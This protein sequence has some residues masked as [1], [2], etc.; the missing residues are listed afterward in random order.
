MH[1]LEP[2]LCLAIAC[3]SIFIDGL[4][5]NE[6][7]VQLPLKGSWMSHNT[8]NSLTQEY[9]SCPVSSQSILLSPSCPW[10]PQELQMDTRYVVSA[11]M[12]HFWGLC[13]SGGSVMISEEAKKAALL[14]YSTISAFIY[15]MVSSCMLKVTWCDLIAACQGH[16]V[17]P[18]E[19]FIP[20]DKC[21]YLCCGDSVLKLKILLFSKLDV[22]LFSYGT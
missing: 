7:P 1:P 5:F 12:T 18:Y 21:F 22:D 9:Y 15:V 13:W 2:V 4:F 6:G 19:M 8:C 3:Y 11:L 20:G 10:I 16:E 14:L 17:P